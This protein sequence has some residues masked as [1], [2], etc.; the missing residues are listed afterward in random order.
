MLCVLL[1][2]DVCVGLGVCDNMCVGVDNDVG[3]VFG[4][5]DCVGSR[6]CCLG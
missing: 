2:A 3:L 1:G 5:C 6:S 4:V